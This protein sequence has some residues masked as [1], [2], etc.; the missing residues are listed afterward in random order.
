MT[1]V[2]CK[3]GRGY[4]SLWDGK[5]AGCRTKEQRAE[6]NRK[7]KAIDGKTGVTD[8]YAAYRDA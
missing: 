2:A 7:M 5:C 3:C 1:G 6:H 8:W 4:V